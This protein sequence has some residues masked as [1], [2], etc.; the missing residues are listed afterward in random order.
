MKYSIL[1]GLLVLAGANC[2]SFTSTSHV[3]TE[4]VERLIGGVPQNW[5][6]V[7]E[8]EQSRRLHFRIAVHSVSNMTQYELALLINYMQLCIS[9]IAINAPLL[10]PQC[11]CLL[12][13]SSPTMTSS[14]RH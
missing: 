7:G 8:P 12:T 9:S 6:E 13:Q 5:Y 10:T 2:S 4:V 3:E 1:S 11:E 14:S